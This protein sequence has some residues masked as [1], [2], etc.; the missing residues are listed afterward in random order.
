MGNLCTP[1]SGTFTPNELEEEKVMEL[2]YCHNCGEPCGRVYPAKVYGDPYDCYPAEAVGP[3][4]NFVDEENNWHCSQ[5]CLDATELR[6][7]DD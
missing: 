5:K 1:K 4:E 7:E 6:G 2:I 3:G